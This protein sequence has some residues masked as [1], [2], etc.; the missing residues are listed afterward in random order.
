MLK[1]ILNLDG[2]QEL[3]KDEQKKVNGGGKGHPCGPI[4]GIGHPS[5]HA[6]ANINLCMQHSGL[7]AN[8]VCWLCY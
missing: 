2:A 8:G 6:H 1:S 4:G 7:W 5:A 3:N